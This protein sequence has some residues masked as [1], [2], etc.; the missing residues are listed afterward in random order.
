M[1]EINSIIAMGV[2]AVVLSAIGL[3]ALNNYMSQQKEIITSESKTNYE[4]LLHNLK[5]ELVAI[6]NSRNGYKQKF[7]FIKN[8]ADIFF[9]EEEL[10]DEDIDPGDEKIL[11]A[12]ATAMY[13]KL[14]KKVKD[15]L[16]REDIENALL[17]V[18]GD[19]PDKIADWVQKFFTKDKKTE[20]AA[21]IKLKETYL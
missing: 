14:P 2:F 12:I 8:N 6:T 20:T 17:K 16:G 9:D 10:F 18:A 5:L 11:P 13:P 1:P 15:L 21:E 7:N 3:K 19:N 4:N